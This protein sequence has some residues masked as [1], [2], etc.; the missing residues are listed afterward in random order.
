[1]V[2]CTEEIIPQFWG[3]IVNFLTDFG[4]KKWIARFWAVM[5]KYVLSRIIYLISKSLS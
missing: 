4:M 1:M 2:S 3:F 5:T